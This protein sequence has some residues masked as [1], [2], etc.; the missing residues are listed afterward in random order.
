MPVP[1]SAPAPAVA[2]L[3]GWRGTL[4]LGPDWALWRGSV[5]DTSMHR[6]FAAQAVLCDGPL[7]MIDSAG[8]SHAGRDFLIEPLVAHRLL[9][10]AQ[11]TIVFIEPR[12][13][14]ATS[15]PDDIGRALRAAAQRAR[16][17]PG[18]T[19]EGNDFWSTW[20]A[21]RPP[22]GAMSAADAWEHTVRAAIDEQL[23]NGRLGLADVA[24]RVHLS[25]ERFRHVFAARIGM[26]FRRFVLWRR[27]RR[28]ALAMQAGTD[29]T[30]AA[31]HAGFADAA[32]FARTL[33][34]SFGVSANQSL[35]RRD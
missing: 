8:V 19:P 4:D 29:V 14:P 30:T 17:L 1:G 7:S 25:A 26:P 27:L 28:A 2:T 15:L 31:H 5:G 20:L 23:G 35:R 11:A 21:S 6:H 22:A 13:L 9:P 32:H 33:R 24:R 16:Q 12:R 34:S 18:P 10:A 3:V